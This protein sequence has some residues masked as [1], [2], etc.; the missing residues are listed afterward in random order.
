MV[1]T[2]QTIFKQVPDVVRLPAGTFWAGS[3]RHYPEEAPR[4]LHSVQ[5]FCIS[6]TPVTNAEFA[7]FVTDTGYVTDAE[8]LGS[9]SVFTPPIRQSRS[10]SDGWA[11]TSRAFWHRPDGITATTAVHDDHP[12]I[13]VTLS[14][15]Q[16]YATWANARLPSEAEWEY[17][18]SFEQSSNEYIWGDE[19][20][21][22][23]RRAAN[24][25]AHGFPFLREG[26]LAAWGTTP[27]GRFSPSPLGLYDVIGNVWEWTS[28]KYSSSH[29]AKTCCS[30]SGEA[31]EYVIKGGSH[32]CS[33]AYCQRYRPAARHPL[34]AD[35][36]TNHVG[37][38][39]AWNA[40][41]TF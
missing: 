21:P 41:E 12:V 2:A 26:G 7:G 30:R 33:P 25:W 32:L 5:A 13:Q 15:A 10:V 27:V 8:R 14:D 4:H 24:I 34:A 20:T 9:G 38:R 29:S 37:F 19:L 6:T 22:D 40:E 18:A 36:S 17:A 11:A 31:S 35:I 28:D 1:I 23:G 16:A 3:D 39:L